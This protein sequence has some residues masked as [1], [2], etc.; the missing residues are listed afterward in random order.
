MTSVMLCS[1]SM[2]MGGAERYLLNL[3]DGLLAEGNDVTIVLMEATGPLFGEIDSRCRVIPINRPRAIK[4]VGA[5]AKVFEE[6]IP[7]IVISFQT[8]MNVIVSIAMILSRKTIP[9][10]V[11]EHAP[12]SNHIK[13]DIPRLTRI[14]NYMM[15][16]AAKFLYRRAY[17]LIGVSAGVIQEYREFT[18]LPAHRVK[19]ISTPIVTPKLLKQAQ[20]EPTHLWLL[21]K[22]QPVIISMGRLEK[23]KDHITLLEAFVLL[24]KQM[25]VRLIIL[26]EGSEREVLESFIADRN[27]EAFVDLP[28]IAINPFREMAHAD[29][30]VQTSIYEGFGNVLVEAMACGLP[31][32][33]TNCPVGPGEILRNGEFGVLLPVRD[34]VSLANEM[35]RMLNLF[36]VDREKIVR[37]GKRRANDFSAAQAVKKYIECISSGKRD[38]NEGK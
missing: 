19:S 17:K 10:I 31:V 12:V 20:Q 13:N 34:A 2:V 3:S 25:D 22:K 23:V 6:N 9:L 14:K 15:L 8:H 21:E 28:G 11:T 16:I 27:I 30:Y 4:S 32:I 5:L 36:D 29:L 38:K 7:D 26:G 18:R 37:A 35:A 24:R 33:S 1:P